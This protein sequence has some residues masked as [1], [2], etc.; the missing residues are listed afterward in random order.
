MLTTNTMAQ[1]RE[2]NK[3]LFLTGVSQAEQFP[4][5]WQMN[6][7]VF[8]RR[9]ALGTLI[10]ACGGF[11]A[12]SNG[13]N[14][15]TNGDAEAGTMAGWTVDYPG[16]IASVASQGQ[17]TGVVYP[18]QGQ[19][20]FSFAIAPADQ[21]RMY[22]TGTNGLGGTTLTLSGF[23]QTE[24]L[25][26][27][28]DSGEAVISLLDASTNILA[29]ASSGALFTTTAQW[30]AFL[31]AVPIPLGAK[32]WRVDLFGTLH[33]GSYVNVFYDN[34]AFQNASGGIG[35]SQITRRTGGGPCTSCC[36]IDHRQPIMSPD[37]SRFVF[38]S[39]WNVDDYAGN[40]NPERN[41]ELFAFNIASNRFQQLTIS[42]NGMSLPYSFQG[43]KI[44]FISC[45]PQFGGNAGTNMQVFGYDLP[46][47]TVTQ[48]VN[49]TGPAPV[50]LGT[51][52]PYTWFA[53][54]DWTNL[55]NLHLDLSADQR[56]LLSGPQPETC[57]V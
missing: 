27:P 30:K 28:T 44:G 1:M 12:T 38:S 32:Q 6:V 24:A 14:L 51:N 56:H 50:Q 17:S 53:A 23:V 25:G 3:R 7:K 26:D 34:L 40:L 48:W 5:G 16:L 45:A 43:S 31:V 52:C 19:S 49:T 57:R 8:W 9:A 39:I 42:S 20:F 15:L 47:Q 29:S 4:V 37:G 46:S 35:L 21:N 33:Y 11:V 36:G 2:P 55:A 18:E 54:G 13:A 41:R 22:Q 10:I